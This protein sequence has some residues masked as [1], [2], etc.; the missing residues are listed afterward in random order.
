VIIE[1]K[2]G[3]GGSIA[4]TY[5]FRAPPDG[6]IVLVGTIGTQIIDPLLY[7]NLK[8]N[9]GDFVAIA[10]L[11]AALS[12]LVGPKTGSLQTTELLIVHARGTSLNY[13]H[14]G[15]GSS[16]YLAAKE[17][18]AATGIKDAVGIPYAGSGPTLQAVLGGFLDFAFLSAPLVMGNLQNLKVYGLASSQRYEG[19][20][21]IPTLAEQGISVNVDAW[22]G[23]F[24]PP[25][26]PEVAL[27]KLRQAVAAASSNPEIKV[28]LTRLGM[29]VMPMTSP[30]EFQAF[31]R[32][33]A[34][35]WTDFV[36]RFKISID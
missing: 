26:T 11:G 13:G 7:K 16:A 29:R 9:P 34:E 6:S 19:A 8:Y 14:W 22:V 2:P 36:K 17:F 18:I 20:P 31:V 32:Q 1:S 30:N 27:V 35:H 24:A 33:E 28:Q 21:Q 10:P 12:F 5:V 15:P 4:A 25:K 3:G 23:L